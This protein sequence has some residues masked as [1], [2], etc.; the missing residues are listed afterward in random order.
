M[1]Q[2]AGQMPRPVYER[3]GFRELR[4]VSDSRWTRL[5]GG[6]EADSPETDLT[7]LW[8]MALD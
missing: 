7:R 5:V 4:Q 8:V 2:E 6:F 3:S 1:L